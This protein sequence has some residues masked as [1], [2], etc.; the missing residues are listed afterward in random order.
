MAQQQPGIFCSSRKTERVDLGS[1]EIHVCVRMKS[2]GSR[3]R[4]DLKSSHRKPDALRWRTD[5]QAE[6]GLLSTADTQK[7]A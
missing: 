1:T 2:Q 7:V 5:G 3:S 4:D 6:R